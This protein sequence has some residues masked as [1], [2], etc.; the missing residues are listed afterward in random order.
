M[1]Q[2]KEQLNEKV[3]NNTLTKEQWVD[4]LKNGDLI[5][6][7]DMKILLNLHANNGQPLK[8]ILIGENLE[9]GDIGIRIQ[10][11][12]KRIEDKI[13]IEL[14][15]NN[16]LG[17]WKHKFRHWLIMF[18]GSRKYDEKENKPY[19]AWTL[20]KELKEAIDFLLCKE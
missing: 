1:E 20:K 4:I 16:E 10:Q 13:G 11:M 2:R 15:E 14:D 17:S 18:N 7:R 8:T 3:L 5:G 6:L 12:G 19:F 9:F